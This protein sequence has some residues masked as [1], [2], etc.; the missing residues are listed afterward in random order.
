MNK[1]FLF[2]FFIIVMLT[3][4]TYSQQLEHM[5]PVG[6]NNPFLKSGQYI[7][8]LY[9]SGHFSEYDNKETQNGT[10]SRQYSVNFTGLIGLT[11]KVTLATHLNF[12]PEQ[13]L[14][15]RLYGGGGDRI[16]NFYVSPAFV[17]SYRPKEN[18]ELFSSV[19]YSNY[20]LSFNDSKSSIPRI[21]GLDEF[22]NPVYSEDTIIIPAQSDID[23][24]SAFIRVGITYS[25]K[26]W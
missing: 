8:S 3:G 5:I 16:S 25:G 7:T 1:R 21:I 10:Q 14:D 12:Y 15:K 20:S 6:Y 24:M 19:D 22:G 4:T 2:S 17:L 23:V 11:N 26:L 13:T 18:L 9:F